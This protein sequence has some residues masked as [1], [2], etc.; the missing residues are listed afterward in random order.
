MGL[1]LPQNTGIFGS[2][3]LRLDKAVEETSPFDPLQCTPWFRPS[4]P[5]H[6]FEDVSVGES[7]HDVKQKIESLGLTTTVETCEA[8]R[9][10]WSGW[11]PGERTAVVVH[12]TCPFR[13]SK[14]ELQPQWKLVNW[15]WRPATHT[16][17]P[18]PDDF[19]LQN[20]S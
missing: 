2:L 3:D 5:S 13:C 7:I 15:T 8:S 12:S 14:A 16:H 20:K 6:P 11:P 4:L 1:S 19:Q 17:T 18:N 10:H 9:F